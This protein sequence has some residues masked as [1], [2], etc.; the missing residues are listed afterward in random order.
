[1]GA[2]LVAKLV[3]KWAPH[4]GH[5]AFRV[6]TVMAV[7]A[8][9][10]PTPEQPA[11][12]YFNGVKPLQDVLRDSGTRTPAALKKAAQEAIREA[13]AVGA[14]EQTKA[15]KSQRRAEYRLTLDNTPAAYTR[16]L[17]KL[18]DFKAAQD[19]QGETVSP[20]APAIQGET[21]TPPAGGDGNSPLAGD[22]ISPSGGDGTSPRGGDGI[23]PFLEEEPQEEP[24]EELKEEE[25]AGVSAHLTVART[26]APAPPEHDSCGEPGC[27]LGF[28]Y[29]P[30]KP[31]GQRNIACPVCRPHQTITNI[32]PLRRR[33]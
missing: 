7:T 18:K 9:D 1:L 24:Q 6:L 30:A 4:L 8:L 13:L 21:V 31:R 26:R 29:D 5:D 11:G 23:S 33:S 16:D 14:V 2:S 3:S 25:E 15:A 32:S 17:Q 10:N 28:R 20:P 22:G 27:E 12:M 19:G